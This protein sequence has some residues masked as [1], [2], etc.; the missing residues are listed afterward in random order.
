M[1]LMNILKLSSFEGSKI[2]S[3]YLRANRKDTVILEKLRL[4]QASCLTVEEE[5]AVLRYFDPRQERMRRDGVN[6]EPV[7]PESVGDQ[8]IMSPNTNSEIAGKVT[9]SKW[10]G[11]NPKF[12]PDED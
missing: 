8:L 5:G 12:Q 6:A 4:I 11:K 2:L 10:L 1:V 7:V 3:S 9:V